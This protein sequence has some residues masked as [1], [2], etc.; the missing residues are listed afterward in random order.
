MEGHDMFSDIPAVRRWGLTLIEVL[1]SITILAVIV[2]VLGAVQASSLRVAAVARSESAA[3]QV[4]VTQFEEIR[5]SNLESASFSTLVGCPAFGMDSSCG[6]SNVVDGY[7]VLSEFQGYGASG[8]GLIRV[9]I[10]VTG[11]RL[12]SA[13][14]LEQYLSCVDTVPAPTIG[15]PGVCDD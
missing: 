7:A 6:E 15:S 8:K 11:G 1:V 9:R 13:I 12:A 2:T 3:L 4:A 10:T 5:A 14:V